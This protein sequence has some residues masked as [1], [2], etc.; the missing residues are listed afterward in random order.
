M[1]LKDLVLKNRSFRRFDPGARIETS[2]LRE[3]VDRAYGAWLPW[4]HAMAVMAEPHRDR[5]TRS[6]PFE[7]RD[8]HPMEESR[9][10]RG[11]RLT[12][13]VVRAMAKAFDKK[14]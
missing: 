12:V 5:K 9:K 11:M 14:G 4:S 3:L 7:W 8:F 10:R 6:Q 2:T 13:E 1:M